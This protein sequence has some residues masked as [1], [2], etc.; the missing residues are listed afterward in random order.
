MEQLSIKCASPGEFK[1]VNSREPLSRGAPACT[2]V[3]QR[4]VGQ[5]GLH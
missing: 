3:D 4:V 5:R 1:G 2:E